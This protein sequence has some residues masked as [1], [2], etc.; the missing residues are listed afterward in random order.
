MFAAASFG[1]ECVE[2]VIGVANRLVG[3]HLSVRRDSVLETV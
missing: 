3:Y 1:K 2:S